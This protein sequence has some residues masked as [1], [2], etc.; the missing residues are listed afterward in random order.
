M[1]ARKAPPAQVVDLGVV[2]GQS[3]HNVNLEQESCIAMNLR[4]HWDHMQGCSLLGMHLGDMTVAIL[5]LSII[6]LLFMKAI[7]PSVTPCKYNRA[8]LQNRHCRENSK[9][10][11]IPPRTIIFLF[12]LHSWLFVHVI[13]DYRIVSNPT[14][15]APPER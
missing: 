13:I 14:V 3:G 15:F 6:H 1:A 4:L 10:A 5:Y 11:K 7:I 2:S 12:Y 8:K 9:P